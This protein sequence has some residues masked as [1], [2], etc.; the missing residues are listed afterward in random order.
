MDTNGLDRYLT[1]FQSARRMLIAPEMRDTRFR[2]R[3]I[4]IA[5]RIIYFTFLID[6]GLVRKEGKERAPAVIPH[7]PPPKKRPPINHQSRYS[8]N[9]PAS[10]LDESTLIYLSI[11]ISGPN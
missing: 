8:S 10:R 2:K 4:N 7:P 5:V 9:Y 11:S 3:G 6:E 1:S